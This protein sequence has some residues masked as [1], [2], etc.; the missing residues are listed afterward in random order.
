MALS[1]ESIYEQA[2]NLPI[3][4]R[5]TLIDKLLNSTNFSTDENIDRVWLQEVESRSQ[6][7]DSGKSE[8]IPGAKVFERIDKK[9]SR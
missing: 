5:I 9:Y 4:D 8:L 7:V 2:L 1:A 6:K 3:D